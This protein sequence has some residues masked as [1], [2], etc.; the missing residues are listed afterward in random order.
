M[1]DDENYSRKKQK[2][3]FEEVVLLKLNKLDNK[4][5]EFSQEQNNK[6]AEVSHQLSVVNKKIDQLET[7]T[8]EMFETIF[9][10]FNAYQQMSETKASELND[11][12][13]NFYKYCGFKNETAACMISGLNGK[14]K[15]AHILPRRTKQSIRESLGMEIEDMNSFRNL[16][17]LACNIE[18]AFDRLKLSFIQKNALDTTLILKIWDDSI[19]TQQIWPGSTQTIGMYEGSALNLSLPIGIY[20]LEPFRRCLSYQALMAIMT[21]SKF[22]EL[23]SPPDDFCSDIEA[24]PKYKA[25]RKTFLDFRQK[26]LEAKH[27][28]MEEEY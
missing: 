5:A 16:L 24:I 8:S 2:V 9:N 22:S 10:E 21:N 23:F 26:F 15:L 13:T 11:L 3:S 19:R 18:D 25:K 17:L 14:L 1:E 28:E 6:L 7:I 4:L 12:R 20:E 27:D